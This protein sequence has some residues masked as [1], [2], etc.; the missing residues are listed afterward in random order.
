MKLILTSAIA[1]ATT[2]IGTLPAL[3]QVL[4]PVVWT[5]S[6]APLCYLV[7]SQGRVYDLTSICGYQGSPWSVTPSQPT[8][9]PTFSSSGS[10]AASSSGSGSSSSGRCDYDWQTDSRGNACGNRA[11]NKKPGGR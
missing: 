7:D 1:L 6:Y 4:Q 3:G 5:H 11:A 2:A 10:G 9:R 8:D